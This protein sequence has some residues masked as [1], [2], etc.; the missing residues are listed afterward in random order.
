[1]SDSIFVLLSI[2]CVTYAKPHT[3]DKSDIQY[4]WRCSN[5][6]IIMHTTYIV[7]YMYVQVGENHGRHTISITM[8][9]VLADIKTSWVIRFVYYFVL[10]SG[11]VIYIYIYICLQICAVCSCIRVCCIYIYIY[12]NWYLYISVWKVYT[13]NIIILDILI[14][15]YIYYIEIRRFGNRTWILIYDGAKAHRSAAAVFAI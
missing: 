2:S 9:C 11:G 8:N 7:L 12:I 10:Y 15:I 3:R 13:R 1:M 6:N 4:D 5:I 14:C